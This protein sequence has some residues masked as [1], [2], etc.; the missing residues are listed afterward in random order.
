MTVVA[1]PGKPPQVLQMHTRQAGENLILP[2]SFDAN[3]ARHSELCRV[4]LDTIGSPY[5]NEPTVS[6][7]QPNEEVGN[8]IELSRS[9]VW[10][11]QRQW[12]G[13]DGDDIDSS[14]GRQQ[15]LA[16]Q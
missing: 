9:A 16:F 2:T 3:I 5:V 8:M 10:P 1:I 7:R 15:V 11:Q 13:R 6:A 12:L 14:I 4:L